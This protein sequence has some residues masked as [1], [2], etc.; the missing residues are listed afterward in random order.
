MN[1]NE[2]LYRK[3][4]GLMQS[5]ATRPLRILPMQE[6]VEIYHHD[7]LLGTLTKSEFEVLTAHEILEQIGVEINDRAGKR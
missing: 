5:S 3:V 7:K 6:W 4:I 2:E 1:Q